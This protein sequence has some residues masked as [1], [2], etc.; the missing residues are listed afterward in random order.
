MAGCRLLWSVIEEPGFIAG[1]EAILPDA[2]RWDEFW[3]A[4]EWAL[5]QDPAGF[6]QIPEHRLWVIISEPSPRTGMPRIR[7]FDA[8]DDA[9]I[10][11]KWVERA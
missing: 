1:R 3:R 10:Y 4:V 7:T 8:F 5:A 9:G 6:D 2:K 11:L